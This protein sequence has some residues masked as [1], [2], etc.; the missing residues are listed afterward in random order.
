MMALYRSRRER[1]IKS[2][3]GSSI[4]VVAVGVALLLFVQVTII[5]PTV[6]ETQEQQQE[7]ID[8]KECEIGLD[9]TCDADT[10]KVDA[11][12]SDK[13]AANENGWKVT[14]DDDG[15]QYFDIGFGVGQQAVGQ[16]SKKIQQR[17]L[18]ITTYMNDRV[19]KASNDN[20]L[21]QVAAECQLRHE[22]CT[23]WA[24]IDECDKNPGTFM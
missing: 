8:N 22:L 11:T 6:A 13:E 20:I 15:L 17:L 14:T 5:T 16:H 1:R 2:L 23:F 24:I 10:V 18:N 7:S 21:H 19:L 3:M 12:A 4:V 9:G